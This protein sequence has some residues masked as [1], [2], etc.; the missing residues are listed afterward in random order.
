MRSAALV[1]AGVLLGSAVQSPPA[2][3]GRIIGV[4]HVAITVDN[5]DDAI[6][7]YNEKMGFPEVW[8]QTPGPNGLSNLAYVQVGRDTFIEVSRASAN[9]RPGLAHVGMRVDNMAALLDRLKKADVEVNEPRKG[10]TATF[11]S[12]ATDPWGIRYEL[13]EIGPESLQAQIIANYR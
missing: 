7:F 12:G 3:P 9:A 13:L 1:F 8:R 5:F 11:T 10:T 4:N 6:R 2:G